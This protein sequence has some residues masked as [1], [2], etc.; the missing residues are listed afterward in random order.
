MK[1]CIKCRTFKDSFCFHKQKDKLQAYCIDCFKILKKEW[2]LSNKDRLKLTSIEK[3]KKYREEN[4]QKVREKSIKYYYDNRE[5]SIKYSK[6]WAKNNRIEINKKRLIRDKKRMDNDPIFKLAS[7][8]RKS[9]NRVLWKGNYTKKSRTH[10]ILGCSFQEFKNFIE[11]KF[12]KWMNWDNHGLYNGEP[13]Y[14]WDL[15]HIIPISSA[16]NEEEVLL[17][18]NYTNFQPLCSKINRNI[19]KNNYNL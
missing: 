19:K 15:D 7:V 3:S 14:G 8:I 18:N 4:I 2:Y 10:E 5:K 17:L 16:K 13:N 1:E 9:I 11:I 12:E 6:E